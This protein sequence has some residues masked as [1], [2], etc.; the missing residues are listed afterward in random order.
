M[1]LNFFW[2]YEINQYLLLLLIFCFFF[3]I[4]ITGYFLTDKPIDNFFGNREDSRNEIVSVYTSIIGTFFAILLG[5]VAVAAWEEYGS[6]EEKIEKEA[7][8]SM[9]LLINVSSLPDSL[10]I[11]VKRAIKK[12]NEEV[13]NLEWP[14]QAKGNIPTNAMN[15]L[16]KIHR[17]LLKFNPE[18]EN[19]KIVYAMCLQ[20]TQEF[21]KAR[22]D[23][24]YSSSNGLPEII[25]IIT[26][27]GCTILIIITW[28]FKTS[29]QLHIMMSIF[30]SLLFSLLVFLIVSLD[31]P[32]RGSTGLTPD[33]FKYNISRLTEMEEM[34]QRSKM[35]NNSINK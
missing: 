13:I 34:I 26:F 24:V 17:I 5:L 14:E 10:S 22:R 15:T 35:P 18:T 8:L 28:F 29:D 30:T 6:A 1:E 31:W 19:Q 2:V 27:L 21:I 4:S 11:P 16:I 23:R 9:T 3:V 32:Y 33:S 25:W 12:Y 7:G 20:T